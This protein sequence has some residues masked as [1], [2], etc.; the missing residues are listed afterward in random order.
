MFSTGPWSSDLYLCAQ[1]WQT[2]D[3]LVTKLEHWRRCESA[4]TKVWWQND[5]FSDPW[6]TRLPR[7]FT[8][9]LCLF[10]PSVSPMIKK[11]IYSSL[12][13]KSTSFF[14]QHNFSKTEE[15]KLY[16]L[17]IN[18]PLLQVMTKKYWY[19]CTFRSD[20]KQDEYIYAPKMTSAI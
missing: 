20:L 2:Y 6:W 5:T 17:T 11:Q 14:Q 18:S 4:A 19:C 1:I 15:I 10:C 3:H 12:F 9:R 8:S 16:T 7:F 13:Q